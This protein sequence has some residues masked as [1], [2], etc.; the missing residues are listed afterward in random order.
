MPEFG[1]VLVHFLKR[2]YHRAKTGVDRSRAGAR[3]GTRGTRLFVG[4]TV[5]LALLGAFSNLAAQ[6]TH[7]RI[8]VLSNAPA[9]IRIEGESRA[10][11]RD[12]SFLQA[13]AGAQGLG[14]RIENFTAADGAGAP[15]K[16]TR[17]APGEYVAEPGAIKWTYEVDL[18]PPAVP[19]DAPYVSWLTPDRGLLL[20][21]DL[22]PLP[23]TAE[24]DPGTA[25]VDL[26]VTTPTGWRIATAETAA[27]PGR[28]GVRDWPSAVFFISPD[29][30]QTNRRVE[31]ADLT[32][33]ASGAWAFTDQDV[34]EMASN[35][36]RY[37]QRAI[38][39]T[40]PFAPML[41]VAPYPTPQAADRW[42][43]ETR[44][45][46]VVLLSGRIPARLPAL[47]TLSVSLTHELF[48]LWVPNRVNLAG[49]YAW[50]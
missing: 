9:R 4:A 14:Q 49:D 42:S 11:T 40:R 26:V 29:H 5:L 12:F 6:T 15:V 17:L 18:R 47:G 33:I 43:A 37:H 35:V 50:F 16:I 44:G 45:R 28:Y 36:L 27:S 31:Q 30:R 39:D 32:V 3:G 23:V 2:K 46:T 7:A 20:L 25:D 13:Y 8:T 19:D 38:K 48:H 34:A 21:K 10:P 1:F 41:I 24:P 22:L